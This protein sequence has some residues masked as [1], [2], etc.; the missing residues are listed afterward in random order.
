MVKRN[1]G[2]SFKYKGKLTEDST[3]RYTM[4]GAKEVKESIIRAQSIG[5]LKHI[6][7]PTI[8]RAK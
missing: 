8:F 1:Y 7:S 4:K 5:K 2:I 6:K 3:K